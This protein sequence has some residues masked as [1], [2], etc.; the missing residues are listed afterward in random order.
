MYNTRRNSWP[1]RRTRR[2]APD[3]KSEHPR[4]VLGFGRGSEPSRPLRQDPG[5]GSDAFGTIVLAGTSE[6]CHRTRVYSC[7][8]CSFSGHKPLEV[9]DL[10]P[11]GSGGFG[12]VYLAEDTWIDKKV[13]IKVPHVRRRLRRAAA[14]AAA[15]RRRSTTPTSSAILTAESRTASSSS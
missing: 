6:R 11:L 1:F 14:G 2:E 3:L 9:Q 8:R 5:H 10:S 15:A 12:T 7:H 4:Q 13:A